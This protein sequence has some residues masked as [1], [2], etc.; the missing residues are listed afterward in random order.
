[1]HRR[2]LVF[3]TLCL[4]FAPEIAAA[5][6]RSSARADTMQ[7]A[8]QAFMQNHVAEAL[9]L[10]IVASR[11][12]P[13]NA[14]RHAWVAE[15][16]RRT[17]DFDLAVIE[18]RR[19]IELKN[20]QSFAH[21]T[22]AALYNPQY[23]T[24]DGASSDSTWAHLMAAVRADSSDGNAWMTI[25]AEAQHHGDAALEQRALQRLV[26][27]G[28]LTGPWM[29]HARWVLESAPPR[30][31]LLANGDIDTYPPLAAQVVSGI[32]SDVA[33]VNM[34]MLDLPWYVE[35]IHRR[36]GVPL[37]QP[38]TTLNG[39]A[40]DAI[41]EH[42]RKHAAA[43][44]LGRPLAVLLTAGVEGAQTGS[45]KPQLA[46]PFWL[47][48]GKAARPD[49]V[50]LTAAYARAKALDWRGPAISTDDRSPVRQAAA[51]N[52]AVIV[53]YV[54]VQEAIEGISAPAARARLAW[55]EDI[56]ARAKVPKETVDVILAGL[57]AGVKQR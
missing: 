23:S 9:P 38:G 13:R 1:M 29:N 17:G 14:C 44:T 47:I 27:T 48:T 2:Q 40:S 34:P 35:L 6:S 46:G 45:G 49:T 43:G 8:V 54:A 3:A 11:Q 50:R 39:R 15:A 32:R 12:L 31:I 52:P 22:L 19:A 28:F 30:A 21:T 4:T 41:I 33:V 10:F 42:W 56:L 18:S 7:L 20:C 5:Q 26:A 25:W 24:W 51:M 16:A 55:A 36:Y 57:R 37:P 53:A